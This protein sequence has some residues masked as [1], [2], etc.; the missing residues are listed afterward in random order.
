MMSAVRKDSAREILLWGG[1][2]DKMK[3]GTFTQIRMSRITKKLTVN[4]CNMHF[5]VKMWAVW[6]IPDNS[7][8]VGQ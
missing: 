2:G 4:Y 7:L 5:T 1:G 8:H 3:M 6:L